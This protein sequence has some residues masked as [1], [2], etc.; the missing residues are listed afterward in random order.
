MLA[1]V[2]ASRR[3]VKKGMGLMRIT[4]DIYIT[5]I[6]LFFYLPIIVL[7]AFSFNESR[8]SWQWHGF[9]LQWYQ[10][11]FSDTHLWL[12]AQHSIFLGFSAA[13]IATTIGGLAAI[14]LR[15][16]RFSVDN[17]YMVRFLF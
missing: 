2:Y 8:F 9:S 12:A 6:Y 5:A 3:E 16:H 1:Y 10:E 15:R 13:T 7:I 4:R 11:L 17:F 14:S